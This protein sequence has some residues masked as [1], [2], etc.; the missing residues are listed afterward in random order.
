MEFLWIFC[1]LFGSTAATPS[2]IIKP[3]P[4]TGMVLQD[5]PGLLITH[6]RIHTQRI[7]VRLDPWDVYHKHVIPAPPPHKSIIGTVQH[8]KRTTAYMLAQLQKFIVTEDDLGENNRPKRF[9]GGLIAAVSAVGSLFSVGLSAANTISLKTVQRHIAELQDEMP[10]IQGNLLLLDRKQEA[11]TKTLQGTLVTVN[12]HSALINESLR[13]IKTLSDTIHQDIVYT[14]VVRDLMQ[15]LL[16]EIGSTLDSLVEGRIPAYLVPMD[17]LKDVL[18]A[19]TPSTVHTS[20]IHLAYSL[21]SAIPIHV[22]AEK[23]ELGF[24]LNVPIIETP[25]IYRL[26]SMLNVGFWKNGKHFHLKTPSFLAYQDADSKLYLTPNLDLC[27]KTKDIH[28]VCLGNPFV[29]DVANYQCGLRSDAP[30]QNCQATVTL[31]DVDMD[32]R[33]ERAGDRWLISTPVDSALVTYDQHNVATELQLPNQTFFLSVPPGAIVHLENLALHHLNLEQHDSEIEIMDAFQ[34]YNFTIDLEIDQQLLIEGTKLVKF[35]QTP[36]ELTLT[37]MNR[38]PRRYIDTDY[39]TLI[40]TLVAL[41]MGWLITAVIAYS[42]YRCVKKLQ[43]KMHL[44][45]YG[46]PR[47]RVRG[48]S[49]RECTTPV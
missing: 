19:A 13:A 4:P 18:T 48:E 30:L 15:D 12:L 42:A 14:R 2:A 38:Y 31:K 39:T 1:I 21:G 34:G 46:V 45:T 47:D 8:A 24:L 40:C 9:L 49:K 36:R 28:W 43:D 17:L 23:L 10:E 7:V 3:G 26:K 22:D 35:T 33:V 27:T 32:T 44:L 41:G 5:N 11:L 25:H 6:C 20:Q 37:P 16:R 29:R